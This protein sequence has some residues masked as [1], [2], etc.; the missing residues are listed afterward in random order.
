MRYRSNRPTKRRVRI[1]ESDLRNIVKQ[2]I[3]EAVEVDNSLNPEDFNTKAAPIEIIQYVMSEVE[4][5]QSR[6]G[7][8]W[9]IIGRYYCPLSHADRSLYN[10]IR[11]AID[12]YC[13]DNGENPDT[14]DVEEIFG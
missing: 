2:V 8:A 6:Y 13:I 11:D 1:T 7:R 9:N 5:F 14:Y 12:D 10:D 4:D 3:R